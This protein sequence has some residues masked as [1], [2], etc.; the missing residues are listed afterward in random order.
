M[1]WDLSRDTFRREL[2]AD[3]KGN[4]SETLVPL[5]DQFA[6]CQDVLKRMGVCQ[7]MDPMYEADDF[8]GTIAKK[9]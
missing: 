3:Y 5:K 9:I 8:C 6:L 2:Y 1:A 7:F 4:R